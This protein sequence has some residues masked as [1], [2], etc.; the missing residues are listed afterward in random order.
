[1]IGLFAPS[2][3]TLVAPYC[4]DTARLSQRYP[5]IA[6]YGVFGCLN[7][8]NWVHHPSP[9]SEHFP[10]GE[11]AKWRCD[12]PPPS[13]GVSQAILVRYPMKTRQNACDNPL[14]DTISK[15]YCG[16]MGGVSHIGAAKC[17]TGLKICT[18]T[19]APVLSRSVAR[20]RGHSKKSYGVYLINTLFLQI[21]ASMRFTFLR[22]GPYFFKVIAL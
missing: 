6:S 5:L 2:C 10:L 21:G 7:M 14:C 11:H 20:P 22:D 12:T 1:M 15:G 8:A 18:T 17:G 9:F 13:K 3:G 4:A 16:D 19:V